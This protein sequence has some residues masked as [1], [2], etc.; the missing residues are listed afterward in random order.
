MVG[1]I[2]QEL[3]DIRVA[4]IRYG[5][6]LVDGTNCASDLEMASKMHPA[7]KRSPTVPAPS[8]CTSPIDTCASG[9]RPT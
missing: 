9:Y 4:I 6:Q 8:V 3:W 1:T 2:Q 7:T 5:L